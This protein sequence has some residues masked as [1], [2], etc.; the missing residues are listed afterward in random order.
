MDRI[1]V[2]KLA[3]L[4]SKTK[5]FKVSITIYNRIGMDNHVKVI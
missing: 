5:N 1:T 3:Y 4:F 2:N